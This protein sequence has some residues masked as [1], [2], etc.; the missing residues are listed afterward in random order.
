MVSLVVV[1]V[2]ASPSEAATWILMGR[3]QW[4]VFLQIAGQGR[5][6]VCIQG[7]VGRGVYQMIIDLALRWI[8][9]N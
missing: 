4:T 1:V 2:A 9:L 6:Q 3:S 8:F 5:E 7:G